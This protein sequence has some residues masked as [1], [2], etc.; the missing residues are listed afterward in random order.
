[1]GKNNSASSADAIHLTLITNILVT[2]IGVATGV[3]TAR[4]LGPVMVGQF[5]AI[6]VWPLIIASVAQMGL[7]EALVYFVSRDTEHAKSYVLLAEL[8]ATISSIIFIGIGWELV[9]FLLS[10]QTKEIVEASRV[11]L[12]VS[13]I[14]SLGLSHSALRGVQE[15]KLWN[16]FRVLP[17]IVWLIV[18]VTLDVVGE[19]NPIKL[20]RLFLLSMFLVAVIRTSVSFARLKGRV[21]LRIKYAGKMLR[22]GLPSVLTTVPQTVNLRL[23][24]FFI[25]ALLPARDLGFYVVAVAWSGGV[26]P[27]LSAVGAVMFPKV[28]ALPDNGKLNLLK[29]GLQGSALVGTIIGLLI[30]LLAPIG[31]PIV[32]GTKFDNSIPSALFL[33]PAGVI[34]AWA[35]VAEEGLRGLGKPKVVLY[36]EI[37]GAVVTVIALIS[38]L[39][40]FGIVGAA[41]AS[42]LG[43]SIV[44]LVCAFALS[45]YTETKLTQFIFPSI[46]TIKLIIKKTDDLIRK[47]TRKKGVI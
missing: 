23:D 27:F 13:I 38:L 20:S 26:S 44:A 14:Y 15:F 34:L 39:H 2:G 17:G 46:D 25:I 7:T 3:I 22:F 42:L 40:P 19:A 1:M 12:I 29:T 5:N 4:I 24:Q 21:M 30:T 10:S 45:R 28:S 9:P 16:V 36:A 8:M 35:G 32:F 18:L 33:V 47:I 41:I 37:I 11:F 43:Y 31:I 6:Q